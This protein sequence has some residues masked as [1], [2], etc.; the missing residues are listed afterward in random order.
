MAM[1]ASAEAIRNME[2]T[3]GDTVKDI[4]HISS[5][6]RTG[7]R[8]SSEW[9]DAKAAEFNTIMQKIARLTETPVATLNAACPKLKQLA[10][11]VDD[12]NGVS[13]GS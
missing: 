1:K 6:I 3:I 2:K 13:F 11:A 7:V 9:N 10:Q 8:A 5:G 4:E 12:Y